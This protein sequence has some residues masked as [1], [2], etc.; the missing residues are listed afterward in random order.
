MEGL[1]DRMLLYATLGDSWTYP[2]RVTFSFVPDGTNVGGLP[3]NL[4]ATLNAQAATATWELAF[5]KAAS[6]W[7]SAAHLNMAMVSDN[8]A[9]IS[10]SGDQQGDPRFGDIRI[11][12]VNEGNN[13]VLASTFLPPPSNGG[14]VAGDIV[15]NSYYTFH[16][17][18]DYDVQTVALHE[19][20]H[21]L[22]LAHSSVAGAAMGPYYSGLIQAPTAD[23]TAGMAAVYGAFP[24]D[25]DTNKTSGT[26][27]DIT[28]LLNGNHQ[29]AIS[30]LSMAGPTDL[31]WFKVTVPVGTSGTMVVTMQ[32][33]GL[34]MVNPRI[35]VYNSALKGLAQSFSTT[36]LGGNAS[37]TINGVTAGQV[38]YFRATPATAP[39]LY[40][41]Y[42]L[43]V[44]LGNV[45][46]A[47]VAPPVT[48]VA[49]QPDGGGGS[50][51]QLA[52]D[53]RAVLNGVGGG[54]GTFSKAAI[55]VNATAMS[56]V[57]TDVSHVLADFVGRG[58]TTSDEYKQILA[59]EGDLRS[60]NIN[61]LKT[62]LKVVLGG[63]I[64]VSGIS[65]FGDNLLVSS[66]P[67]TGRTVVKGTTPSDTT[68]GTVTVI[69][70]KHSAHKTPTHYSRG[71]HPFVLS[72]A[73]ATTARPSQGVTSLSSSVS[74]HR[75]FSL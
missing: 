54:G 49:A 24:S 31:D 61:A 19:L 13:G 36:N 9:D 46:Q 29:V 62:D 48:T 14:T 12:M 55:K 26:A 16:L 21:A 44:N 17:N 52:G 56:S 40:G 34:S 28:S 72:S 63:I 25:T 60:G 71:V 69:P 33:G 39:G 11:S 6:Y 23:D 43:L 73:K 20:G 59:V 64:Q 18:S 32:G 7:S 67:T 51:G 38:Y 10:T 22:G 15:F 50:L 37:V 35:A 53:A 4:F 47:Q 68:V 30:N 66:L 1:E 8:G 2:A 58:A 42:A 41:A 27:T 65:G 57:A 5:L 45:A 3:S 75:A 70:T 74:S